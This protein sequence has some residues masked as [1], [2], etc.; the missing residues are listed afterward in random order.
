MVCFSF[1][2]RT[3][4]ILT[5]WHVTSSSAN[6]TLCLGSWEHKPS[7]RGYTL[8]W[9]HMDTEKTNKPYYTFTFL[10]FFHFVPPLRTYSRFPLIMHSVY[11]APSLS[12][13]PSCFF[14]LFELIDGSVLKQQYS[15]NSL[16]FSAVRCLMTVSVKL[17]QFAK[18]CFNSLSQD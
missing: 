9:V 16:Q 7:E 4:P 2:A 6:S 3:I 8:L 15:C 17:T 18:C 10:L 13:H 12:Q 1:I 5:L 14:T 11:H